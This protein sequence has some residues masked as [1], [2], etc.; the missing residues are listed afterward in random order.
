M[1]IE[2]L[3]L[4][5][6]GVYL[7]CGEMMIVGRLILL[8]QKGENCNFHMYLFLLSFTL[9]QLRDVLVYM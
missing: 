8:V 1:N 3:Q 9:L 2:C 4:T 5:S 6:V 7:I